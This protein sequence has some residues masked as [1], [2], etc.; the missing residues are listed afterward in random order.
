MIAVYLLV[1]LVVLGLIYLI[2]TY[3]G[4]VS[5]KTQ[6]EASIQEIGNQLK[7]QAEVIPNLES[8][9]KGYLKHEKKI[10]EQLTDARKAVDAA[11]KSGSSA[12]IEKAQDKLG[13]VLPKIQVMVESNPEIKG[14]EVVTRLMNEL[15]DTS[16]KVMY[17]RRTLIDLTQDFN[18]M[19]VT[20][21]SNMVGNMF[22][23]S[24]QKGLE[25]PSEG[26]HLRVSERE[27]KSPK[28]DL[29]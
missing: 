22:G 12:A 21:P 18:R 26:E 24:K 19:L 11:V 29:E 25:T 2:G 6:I 4:F 8:A 13:A 5:I 17:A 16:D 23:M 15:R 3:N 27:M 9:A 20:F 28:V 10:F 7:R 1:G 14:V